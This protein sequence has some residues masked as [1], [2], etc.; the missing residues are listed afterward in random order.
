MAIHANQK[1][2]MVILTVGVSGCEAVD[3][4]RMLVSVLDEMDIGY[5]EYGHEFGGGSAQTIHWVLLTVLY[6]SVT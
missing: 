4:V 5:V 2:A 1:A 3:W 6:V